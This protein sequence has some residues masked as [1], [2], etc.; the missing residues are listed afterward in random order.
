V[1]GDPASASHVVRSSPPAGAS[2]PGSDGP[3]YNF[4]TARV[5]GNGSFGVVYQATCLETGETVSDRR[6]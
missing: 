3:E 4:A 5:V 2:G 6:G 1:E